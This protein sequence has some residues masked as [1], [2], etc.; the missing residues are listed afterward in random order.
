[1]PR[2]LPLS[3]LVGE[4]RPRAAALSPRRGVAPGACT[5]ALSW[6][7]V[8]RNN[9]ASDELWARRRRIT[10]CEREA[11]RAI[12]S[13]LRRELK[14]AEEIHQSRALCGVAQAALERFAVST[15]LRELGYFLH[16]EEAN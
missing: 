11:F 1:M 14:E 8:Q 9:P 16:P 2:C 10:D 13:L 3:E 7:S 4:R 15:A 12:V 6:L 5:A